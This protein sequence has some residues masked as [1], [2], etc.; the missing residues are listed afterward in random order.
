MGAA[1]IVLA[2]AGILLATAIAV[3]LFQRS[4]A[5]DDSVRT[6][7]MGDAFGTMIDVFDPGQARAH[8]DLKEQQN[9]GPVTK[10]PERDPD[11]P[12]QIALGADGMPKS[13]RIRRDR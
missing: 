13:V 4:L 9:V 11:D 5:R 12:I 3:W 2:I 10:T 7:S 8:R 6:S 1:V